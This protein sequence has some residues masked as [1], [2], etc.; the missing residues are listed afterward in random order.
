MTPTGVALK[1][2]IP[3]L[4]ACACWLSSTGASGDVLIAGR[5]FFGQSSGR[6]IATKAIQ[7]RPALS[8]WSGQIASPGAKTRRPFSAAASRILTS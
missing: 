2:G 4:V 8:H 1:L 7:A 3:E 6:A 5:H